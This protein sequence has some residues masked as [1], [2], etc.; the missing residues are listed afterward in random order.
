MGKLKDTFF[1]TCGYFHLFFADILSETHKI[2]E[3]VS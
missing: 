2:F 1:D 3:H